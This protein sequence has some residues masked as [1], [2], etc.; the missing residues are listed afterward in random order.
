MSLWV[1]DYGA[2]QFMDGRLHEIQLSP[3]SALP[4]LFT[5]NAESVD[6]SSVVAGTYLYGSEYNALGGDDTVKLPA[7]AVAAAQAGYDPSQAF[8]GW[9]G[10][11]TITGGALNDVIYGDGGNDKLIGGTGNDVLYGLGGTDTL[12]GGAGNDQLNGGSGNDT[13]D[14]S[15][16]AAAVS[17]NLALGTATGEGNDILLNIENATGSGFDDT[18][19][20]NT[21]ANVLIGGS[22]TDTLRGGDGNDTLTGGSGLDQ[23]FGEDGHDTL[24]WDNADSFDGGVGFDTLDAN[25]S[26]NDTFDLRASNFAAL[27]R[28]LTGS[29]IDAVTLS[30]SKVMSDT[31]DDQFVADLGSGTDTLKID[32]TGGWTATTSNPTLGPTAVA[33]GISVAGMTAYT[34]TNGTNT[35]TIFTNAEAVQQISTLPPLF[36]VG[37]D[38]IN[39]D[40]IAAGTYAPGSQYDALAGNDT[41][42]LPVDAAAA[43]AAGY[44]ATQ[45]FNAGDGNDLIIGGTLNDSISG[46]NGN[47]ALQGGDGNDVLTGG[48]NTDRLDGGAG[49][50]SLN[51][52]SSADTLVGGLGNDL[53]D[54]GSSND[55]ADYS[56]STGAIAADLSLGTA[57]G[58]GNDTL[59]NIENVTGSASDD[60]ITGN[61]FAN[62]LLGGGGNDALY[63]GDGNDR[64]TGG[65]GIDQLLG[66]AGHDTLKWDSADSFDGGVG[67]DTL[68]ANLSSSDTIDLRGTGFANLERILTGGGK[69]VVTLSLNDVLSDTADHQF[70]ADLGSGT[71]TLHIDVTGG[72]TATAPDGTL[73]PTGVAAGI[74]IS[75][76]T[77][78]TFTDGSQTVTVFASAE[79]IDVV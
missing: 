70:V 61:S 53:L 17:V 48:S 44:S 65:A 43:A 29:G 31:A 18:I 21:L 77:A 38:I 46:G 41:V 26:S 35:V 42:T 72:W 58:E 69:D 54:G 47:D 66:D 59:L 10:N 15:A 19:T 14:Y 63:G 64:L 24:K 27:E 36:T 75:G 33:A 73:G 8:H 5:V 60:T 51:G 40:Q 23:L 25:L 3:T 9:D 4:P 45:T 49:N 12:I 7:D 67:F 76:L 16:S 20:G 74:S 2:D 34:F 78:H 32:L 79:V 11:D 13:V 39:F 56:A 71:D 57:T 68:D 28:I 37:D 62:V 1:A 22:G 6:F 52:G 55:T 50:D 30:L